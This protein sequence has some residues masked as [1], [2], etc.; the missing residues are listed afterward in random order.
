MTQTAEKNG[1]DG[2]EGNISFDDVVKEELGAGHD[3]QPVGLAFSGGGIRSATFHLGL[4]QGLAKSGVLSKF[5]YLSTVSGGGYIG[6]WLASWAKRAGD[7]NEVQE[8]LK[9]QAGPV[10]EPAPVAWLRRYSNYLTPRKGPL[11]L[12]T[13]T[14]VTYHMRNVFLSTL[15]IALFVFGLASLFSVVI[16]WFASSNVRACLSI[17]GP[18]SGGVAAMWMWYCLPLVSG[19]QRTPKTRVHH[20][21]VGHWQVRSVAALSVLSVFCWSL[22]GGYLPDTEVQPEFTFYRSE[23][24]VFAVGYLLFSLAGMLMAKGRSLLEIRRSGGNSRSPGVKLRGLI[25]PLV[26]TSVVFGLYG[27]IFANL[28]IVEFANISWS[29]IWLSAGVVAPIS[30]LVVS[31]I[32]SIHLG[33]AGRALAS[34]AYFWISRASGVMVQLVL[35]LCILPVA[36]LVAPPAFDLLQA[37]AYVSGFG[38]IYLV[39]ARWLASSSRIGKA[40]SEANGWTARIPELTVQAAPYILTAVLVGLMATAVRNVYFPHDVQLDNSTMFSAPYYHTCKEQTVL[41]TSHPVAADSNNTITGAPEQIVRCAP[42]YLAEFVINLFGLEMLDSHKAFLW[43]MLALLV[44]LLLSVKIDANLFSLHTYYRNRLTNAYLAASAKRDRRN[45]DTG[46]NPEDSLFLEELDQGKPYLLINTTLNLCGK[47]NDLSWQDRKATSFVFSPKYC[48]FD[49]MAEDG[50][51]RAH[52]MPT[53]EF[54]SHTREKIK[55]N[56]PMTIS[57]ASA[58]PLAGYHTKPGISIMLALLGARLGWWF[59]NPAM[60]KLWNKGM[61]KAPLLPTFFNEMLGQAN[62][63]RKQVY[64]SDGGHFENLGIYELVKR[65]CALI[66]SGDS[67]ADPEFRFDDL[68]NAIHKIRVDFGIEIEIN[69]SDIRPAA[70]ASGD[71]AAARFSAKSFVVGKI[72]YCDSRLAR[73]QNLPDGVLVYVKTSLPQCIETDALDVLYYASSHNDFPHEP[74]SDQWFDEEQFEAYRKLGN[75]IGLQVANET[76][77][78]A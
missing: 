24:W 5:D 22:S 40:N 60:S 42:T 57:G 66:V 55:L 47:T 75:L 49:L 48:G 29:R 31:W 61:Q 43:G 37:T 32:I 45:P 52:Y 62:I 2:E 63:E 53:K 73:F 46:I 33:M 8:E 68:A 58:S 18:L 12:D 6:A 14:G 21:V 7:I 13:L 30:C 36:F 44:S 19:E 71:N 41:S 34:E 25:I 69:P 3:R 65:R 70:K 72:R 78:P 76:R 10:T 16:N 27:G 11:S 56:L 54:A 9:A 35:G 77:F 17:L 59:P 67:S 26:L 1:N 39:V 23:G 74:T 64:L 20:V 38:A 4:I 15:T 50:S 28:G 51:A